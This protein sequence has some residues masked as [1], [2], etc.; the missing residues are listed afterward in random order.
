M[1]F[2]LCLVEC[3]GDSFDFFI[4]FLI[5]LDSVRFGAGTDKTVSVMKNIQLIERLNGFQQ[6]ININNISY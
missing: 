6:H 4:R 1:M 2:V 3:L 5:E